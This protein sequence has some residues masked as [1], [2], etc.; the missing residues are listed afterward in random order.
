MTDL[1]RTLDARAGAKP[2]TR[3]ALLEHALRMLDGGKSFDGLSLRELTREVGIVPTAFYRHFRD[4]D[5]LGL[6]LVDESFRMLREMIRSARG[7]AVPPKDVI[8]HSVERLFRQIREHRLHFRFIARER[9]GGVESIRQGIRNEIRL[10]ISELATDLARF[11]FLSKWST[12]DLQMIA[13][14]MVDAMVSIAERVLDAPAQRP[15]AEQEVMRLA[16]KQ[17]RLIVLAVPHW[18]SAITPLPSS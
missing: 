12:E 8:H 17:L 6:A 13:T 9:H 18:R 4:M 11:P 16:E 5:E 14:L 3:Q 15:E 2:N 7:Q 10:F 1:R